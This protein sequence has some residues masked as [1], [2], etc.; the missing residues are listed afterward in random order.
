[1]EF[2]SSA[3]RSLKLSREYESYELGLAQ[4]SSTGDST[5]LAFMNDMDVWERKLN[6]T[7]CLIDARRCLVKYMAC[8][9][10]DEQHASDHSED[11]V[12]D[13]ADVGSFLI[14]DY[15]QKSVIGCT[16][17]GKTRFIYTG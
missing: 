16:T 9:D 7:A 10:H 14:Y 17:K 12:D 6:T 5:A 8:E 3:K 2:R 4:M 1:M 15:K 11:D 13:C